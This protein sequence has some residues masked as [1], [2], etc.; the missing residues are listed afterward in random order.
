MFDLFGISG[1]FNNNL[2]R[3][4]LYNFGGYMSSSFHFSF[5]AF[6]QSDPKQNKSAVQFVYFLYKK[7][8]I[9]PENDS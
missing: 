7:I 3:C 9:L 4:L 2:E 5:F 8:R 6:G 1:G